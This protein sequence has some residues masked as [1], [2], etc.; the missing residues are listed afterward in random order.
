MVLV[1]IHFLLLA[2]VMMVVIKMLMID[3]HHYYYNVHVNVVY[4]QYG[5]SY[6]LWCLLS[7]KVLRSVS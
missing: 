1:V 6:L 5:V 4:Q 3:G 2:V 7:L